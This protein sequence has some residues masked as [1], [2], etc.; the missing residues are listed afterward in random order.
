MFSK[1]GE[2][3]LL[4]SVLNTINEYNM[5]NKDDKVLVA[6]SGGCDSVCLCLALIE[7]GINFSVAHVNHNIRVEAKRDE[8]FVVNFAKRYNLKCYI[9]SE[10]VTEIAK[11]EKISLESAGRNVRYKFFEELCEK[12]DYNKIAVAHNKN[13]NCETFLLN[14]VRGS[15]LNG[16]TGI[17]PVRGK[18]IRPL[19]NVERSEIERFVEEKGES[20]VTDK[21]NFEN[22]YTRNK[23]RNIIIP[24]FLTINEN[25][26][27]N[28]SNT[29]KIANESVDFIDS[30]AGMLIVN[31]EIDI[32]EFNKVPKPVSKRAL[33]FA[34]EKIAGT[35]KDFE[36]KH[37]DFICE[38]LKNKSHGKII[39][40][41]FDVECVAEYG[42]IIFRKKKKIQNYEY[43][44]E[45][46]G[47][48]Y[49]RE[50][51]LTISANIV[52]KDCKKKKNCQYF[53]FDKLKGDIIIRNRKDGDRVVPFKMK[54]E[55]KLKE[56]MINKKIS[57]SIRDVLPV[58]ENDGKIIMI[59]DVVRS[60]FYKVEDDTERI[61][62]IKGEK[63]V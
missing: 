38:F 19:I 9:K 15:G 5:L 61:L 47:K 49:I 55:K 4:K 8:N 50:L 45:I 58:V 56:I 52:D 28:I 32:E 53:D 11:K 27:N 13:D 18:V 29:I 20:Y 2:I 31:D 17:S 23:I 34:Y 42:K 40:L 14:L 12:H 46:G 3:I 60:D 57:K 44:L 16:L 22:D 21:T 63:D 36:K 26:I 30:M 1:Q 41:C 37:I 43:K 62:E 10:N 24:E 48:I 39:D 54:N 35:A 51:G 25:F 7:M 6:F 59:Y 33:M